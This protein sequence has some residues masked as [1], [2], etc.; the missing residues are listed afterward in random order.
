M[1]VGSSH[2]QDTLSRVSEFVAEASTRFARVAGVF[3]GFATLTVLDSIHFADT[4]ADWL[5]DP[6]ASVD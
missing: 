6:L 4:E 3:I 5:D 2:E 1:G